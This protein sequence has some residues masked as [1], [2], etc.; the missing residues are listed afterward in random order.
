[1]LKKLRLSQQVFGFNIFDSD[2]LLSDIDP[3]DQAFTSSLFENG[4]FNPK[5]YEEKLSS[6]LNGSGFL[7]CK[8]I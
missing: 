6:M 8:L 3:E 4:S 2:L 5:A 1:M 7:N